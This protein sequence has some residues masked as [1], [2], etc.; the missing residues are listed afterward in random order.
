[1]KPT[2][3][4]QAELRKQTA[5]LRQKQSSLK[6]S[7]QALEESLSERERELAGRERYAPLYD[8][9]PRRPFLL[10]AAHPA[11]PHL[12]ALVLTPL[13]CLRRAL[14]RARSQFAGLVADGASAEI[15]ATPFSHSGA[16]SWHTQM[17]G[18]AAA[19]DD[20]AAAKGDAGSRASMERASSPARLEVRSAPQT[21][22]RAD[23]DF[24][25]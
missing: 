22:R 1:M 9:C 14:E 5:A 6:S 11:H 21:R 17:A 7:A 19:R 23:E 12:L 3:R 16:T 4:L 25:F 15:N 24:F 8:H 13:P 10:D 18:A 20:A 2:R